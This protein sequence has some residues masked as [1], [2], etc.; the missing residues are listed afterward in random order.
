MDDGGGFVASWEAVR[1]LK[2]L[3]LRPAR[4]VRAIV[5]VNEENGE[6]GGLQYARDFTASGVL[7]KHSMVLETD[8]GA[9]SPFGIGVSCAATANGGCGAAIAQLTLLGAELLAPIGSGNVTPGG[10]GTDIDASCKTGVPCV[11]LNVLDARL[12]PGAN[13]PC[14]AGNGGAWGVPVAANPSATYDS[15]Y[16]FTHHA[17][18]DTMERLDPRQLNHVAAALATWAYAVASLPELLP[19]DAPAPPS[20]GGGASPVV[21]A[22]SVSAAVLV[23]AAAAWMLRSRLLTCG[24]CRGGAGG[25]TP[26]AKYNAV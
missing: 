8:S 6:A 22:V 21:I 26:G 17:A 15:A 1:T 5:W 23:T 7:A 18:S 14:T 4:T 19:R 9:F 3:G 20:P 16:F 25:G 11:G 10:G 13:N 2:V 12:S 24:C